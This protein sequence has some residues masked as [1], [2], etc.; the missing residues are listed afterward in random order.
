MSMREAKQCAGV[1]TVLRKTGASL[2]TLFRAM[3]RVEQRLAKCVL[4]EAKLPLTDVVRTLRL[5][6]A[7]R[8]QRKGT[9]VGHLVQGGVQTRSGAGAGGEPPRRW[10]PRR[11]LRLQY[12][13]RIIWVDAKKF[14]IRPT[15]FKRWGLRG[16][17]S[18]VVHDPRVRGHWSI[19]YYSA[20]T[21][22]HGALH[23][24]LVTGTK[25]P[26]Y[27][28]KLSY[29]VSVGGPEYEWERWTAG[30]RP[31]SVAFS[32]RLSAPAHT[33]RSW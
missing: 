24:K 15:N 8:L 28:P 29:R 25:G 30:P 18:N 2:R 21:Y 3:R 19:H 13:R 20:V 26:G 33:R 10:S 27:K 16:T 14:Y 9:F 12:V 7:L 5:E 31:R 32:P 23:I 11:R 4:N 1:R 22:N 17:P 6:C